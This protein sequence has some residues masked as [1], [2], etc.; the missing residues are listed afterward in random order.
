MNTA[1]R[2]GGCF[3]TG[4]RQWDIEEIGEACTALSD[5]HW[6]KNGQ[7]KEGAESRAKKQGDMRGAT[8]VPE[9]WGAHV[10]GST[11]EQMLWEPAMRSKFS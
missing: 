2:W 1:G 4:Q 11:I 7:P 5:G 8:Q 10:R 9:N 6:Q 3:L